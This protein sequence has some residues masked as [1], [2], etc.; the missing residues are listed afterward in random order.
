MRKLLAKD[1][2]H[3]C[4]RPARLV[5]SP[6]RKALPTPAPHGER[7]GKRGL[8]SFLRSAVPSMPQAGAA[9]WGSL[10]PG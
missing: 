3:Q 10:V 4:Q 5:G 7:D 1:T 9:T 2:R 6:V 8:N